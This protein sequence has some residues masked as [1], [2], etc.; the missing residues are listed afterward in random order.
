MVKTPLPF[1]MCYKI[2]PIVVDSVIAILIYQIVAKKNDNHAF[3]SG[4]LYACSPLS[5]LINSVHFHWEP[6]FIF[7]LLL[8]FYVRDFYK[9]SFMTNAI[10]GIS[11]GISLLLKPVT[12]IFLPLFFVPRIGLKVELGDWWRLLTVLAAWLGVV[13]IG[14]YAFFKVCSISFSQFFA[15]YGLM[16]GIGLL[17]FL[18]VV[19]S[20]ILVRKPKAFMQP[21]FRHYF[22]LQVASVLGLSGLLVISF[23]IFMWLGFD[24]MQRVEWILRYMNQGVQ[25][26]GLPF[27]FPFNKGF[28][29]VLLRNRFWLLGGVSFIVFGYYKNRFD[30]LHAIMFIYAL[31]LGFS[32]LGCQYL[33]WLL[34]FLCINQYYRTYV[35]Y[36]VVASLFVLLYDV[37][38]FANP[39]VAYQCVSSFIPLKSYAWLTPP[40]FFTQPIFLQIIK[41]LGNYVIP[42]LCLML[43]CVGCYQVLV[44]RHFDYVWVREHFRLLKSGYSVFVLSGALA[45]LMCYMLFSSDLTL[46]LFNVSVQQKLSWYA[47]DNRYG[48]LVPQYG[49]FMWYNSISLFLIMIAAW[50]CW[51]F[52]GLC[53]EKK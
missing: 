16:L 26:F 21:S 49:A 15:D 29:N 23:A 4:M 6:L 35:L 1:A 13:L 31:I 52:I 25:I 43:F 7:Y 19:L 46:S 32:G 28:L 12:L 51:A 11:F 45:M 3:L 39:D 47:S 8:A 44:Q 22:A 18:L 33:L 30:A 2:L 36:T 38:P 17:G 27:A 53:K 41:V 34:P 14:C 24:L 37:H 50:S 48:R 42:G 10:F 9:P 20:W 5:F 40:L